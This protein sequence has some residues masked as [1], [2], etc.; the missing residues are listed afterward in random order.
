MRLPESVSTLRKALIGLIY[1][2]FNF[3][4]RLTKGQPLSSSLSPLTSGEVFV[5][6]VRDRSLNA[7][8]KG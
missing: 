5:F 6:G 3:A 2:L 4:S 1:L 8:S 7:Y